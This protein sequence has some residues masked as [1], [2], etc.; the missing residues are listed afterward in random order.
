[1]LEIKNNKIN[2]LNMDITFWKLLQI[3]YIHYLTFYNNS[4]DTIIPELWISKLKNREV[5]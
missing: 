1:M 4:E 5:K 3:F 2:I